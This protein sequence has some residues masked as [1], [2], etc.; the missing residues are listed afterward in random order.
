LFSIGGLPWIIWGVCARVSVS[1]FGHWLIGYFAHNTGHRSW[2]LDRVAVQG[3]NVKGFGLI[4]FGECWHNNHHAFPSSAKLGLE[5]NQ[6][7][8]GWLV[9]MALKRVGLVWNV[10]T[11]DNLEHRENLRKLN[12]SRPYK[13][14]SLAPQPSTAATAVNDT[15]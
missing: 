15:L 6:A 8:P 7:D 2:H 9:L 4:T 12:Q 10:K 14:H 11:P 1:V 5:H 13:P 3:Y